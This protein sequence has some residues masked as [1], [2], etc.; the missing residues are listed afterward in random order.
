MSWSV[1]LFVSGPAKL[2][3]LAA[4]VESISGIRLKRFVEDGEERYESQERE[5]LVIVSTHDLSNDGDREYENYSYQIS[6]WPVGRE[7]EDREVSTAFLTRLYEQLEKRDR[8]RLMLVRN[9][10]AKL[11][12]SAPV[13]TQ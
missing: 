9:L 6:V 12:E 8:Y 10:G 1:D 7:D 11:R 3:D 4:E 13:R 5:Y 2:S